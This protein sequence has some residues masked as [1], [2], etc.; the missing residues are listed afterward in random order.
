[1]A[2]REEQV[3]GDE[4]GAMVDFGEKVTALVVMEKIAGDAGALCHPVEP[5]AADAAIV[6]DMVVG[7]DD[8]D[9]GVELDAG[10]FLTAPDALRVA[11]AD[12]VAGH[13][14]E[15]TTEAADDAGLATVVYPIVADDVGADVLFRPAPGLERVGDREVV[16]I[17]GATLAIEFVGVLAE[18]DAGT[19]RIADLVVLDD[20]ALV[21]VGAD[22][23]ALAHGGCGPVRRGIAQF[24]AGKGD[25]VDAGLFRCEDG[26]A[27]ADLDGAGVRIGGGREARV[28]RRVP[29]L[30]TLLVLIHVREP[31]RLSVCRLRHRDE[32]RSFREPLTMQ[33]DHA[34]PVLASLAIKPVSV[35]F[36]GVGV[37]FAKI[38]VGDDKLPCVAGDSLPMGEE[39]GARDDDFFAQR[40]TVGDALAVRFSSARRL[41]PLAVHASVDNDGVARHGFGGRSGNRL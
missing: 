13:L 32:I 9:G 39:V 22:E 27:Y 1:S 38:G 11:V 10:H 33:V 36:F 37:E 8:I 6:M 28:N 4:K 24:E 30:P 15:G 26:G 31:G 25:V 21:P 41:H 17:G 5:D 19:T 3:V 7:D 20:P 14:A 29:A 16:A 34:T 18:R 23:T 12:V 2:G 40:G 35:Y